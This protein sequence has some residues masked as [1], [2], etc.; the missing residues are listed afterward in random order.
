MSFEK[1]I[2][3]KDEYPNLH[4]FASNIGYCVYDPSNLFGNTCGFRNWGIF[5]DVPQLS[6]GNIQSR[7]APRQ[8]T[9]A[10]KYLMDY[11][12]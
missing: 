5:S 1:Q 7:D 9:R 4:R 6:L 10:R 8:I 11:K 12:C 2:M 3:S